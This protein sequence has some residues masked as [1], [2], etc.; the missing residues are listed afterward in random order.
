M[1]RAVLAEFTRPERVEIPFV[2]L[3]RREHLYWTRSRARERLKTSIV[4]PSLLCSRIFSEERKKT[5]KSSDEFLLRVP[6]FSEINQTSVCRRR[7]T[8]TR[9]CQISECRGIGWTRDACVCHPDRERCT[10][11]DPYSRSRRRRET[12]PRRRHCS[13]RRPSLT[14]PGRSRTRAGSGRRRSSRPARGTDS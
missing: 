4:Q 14:H 3:P 1:E 10:G 7:P 6:V 11:P 12:S 8:R 13:C 9:A 2:L 5:R